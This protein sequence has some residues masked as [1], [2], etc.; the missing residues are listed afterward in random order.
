VD[1]C[2]AQHQEKLRGGG[3]LWKSAAV[4]QIEPFVA[5]WQVVVSTSIR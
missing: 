2:Q 3:K 5:L 4:W 1:R